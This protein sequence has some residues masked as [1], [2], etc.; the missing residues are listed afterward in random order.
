MLLLKNAYAQK[1][2][3]YSFFLSGE[4]FIVVIVAKIKSNLKYI[5]VA[6]NFQSMRFAMFKNC[7]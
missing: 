7:K 2:S 1:L 4:I 5:H 6:R 3:P